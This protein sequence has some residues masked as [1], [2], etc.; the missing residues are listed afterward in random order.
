MAESES[1]L[2]TD[3]RITLFRNLA[4]A[5]AQD[6][7]MM[8]LIRSGRLVGFYHE[9]GIALAPGVAAG[10]YLTKDDIMWP[11]YRAHGLAHLISKGIDTR[12]YFAEHMGREAGCCSGRSSFHLSYPSDHVFGFSGNIGANFPFSVGYGLAAKRKGLGQVVMSCS[13]DGSYGEGRAHEALLVAANWALP[14]VFWCENNGMAQHSGAAD[15]FPMPDI[16]GLAA[17]FGI[18]AHVVDGQDVFDCAEMAHYAIES[19]RSGQGPIFV[20]CKTLRAQEHNVGGVNYEGKR[21][22][23]PALMETWKTD[24]NPLRIAE[25]K[26]LA[27]EVLTKTEIDRIREE[28]ESECEEIEAFAEA[29][30]KA[31][32]SI[33]DLQS[34]VYAT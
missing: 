30:P 17:G 21:A 14:I 33:D 10:H 4:R 9:G 2:T 27:D 31:M 6:R 34:A 20:E 11:H 8:R 5:M 13:G 29:S 1:R 23:D 7:L 3:D 28:V 12:S 19:A 26:L 16:S 25:E 18:E 22:R 24:R 15:I 32:P